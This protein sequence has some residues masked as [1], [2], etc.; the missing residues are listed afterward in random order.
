MPTATSWLSCNSPRT[1]A[2]QTVSKASS[3]R[4]NMDDRSMRAALLTRIETGPSDSST[5]WASRATSSSSPM[6]AWNTSAVPPASVM[7]PRVAAAP[8]ASLR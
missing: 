4:S 6:S 3:E 2:C 7:A 8:S 1:F 5:C